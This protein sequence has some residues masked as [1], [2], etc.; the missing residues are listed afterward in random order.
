[1]TRSVTGR[2]DAARRRRRRARHRLPQRQRLS[3]GHRVRRLFGESLIRNSA[4]LGTNV[5]LGTVTGLGA[6]ILLT[7]LYP[8]RAIGLSAATLS[9]TGLITAISQL[10]LNYS[11][12]RFLPRTQ[13][14][15]DMINSALTATLLVALVGSVIFLALPSAASLYAM[16]G[17]AFAAVFLVSTGL[18]AGGSQL[19]NVFVAD[20]AADKL[21]HANVFNSVAR[22]AA[23]VIFVSAG[24]AGAY[25]AQGVVPPAVE[26]IV[27]VVML[28]RRGQRFR[29]VLS[30]SATRELR[31]FSVGTYIAG[32]IG[33]L[34][35]MVLPLVIV[36]RFGA[37]QSAYWY[38]AIAGASFLFSLPGA[39]SQALLAE[40]SHRPS[41]RRALIRKSAV[42]IT[43]VMVPVLLCAYLAAP[44]ALALL[45]HRYEAGALAT[46][47]WLIIAA[48]MSS[49]NYISGTIL[50]LAKKAFAIAAINTVDAIV[51]LGLAMTWAHSSEEVAQAWV[52]GEVC[53]VVLFIACAAFAL[54]QVHGRWEALGDD[55]EGPASSAVQGTASKESQQAGLD[56]LLS[57]ATHT[58]TG[59]IYGAGQARPSWARSRDSPPGADTGSGRLT[60]S[61]AVPGP[62]GERDQRE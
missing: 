5:V 51:V 28:A 6:L 22:L 19:Q 24:V 34:P 57:L 16:G 4:F 48:A 32:L 54:H 37:S 21:V 27:L 10:G 44:L 53:N 11:L 7:R 12:V 60:E 49:V 42:L 23:P 62:S 50:Y 31:R 38:T 52:I 29:P 3:V 55:E 8:V 39:V 35:M 59:P 25:L 58:M 41:A 1:M 40:A 46:L 14:R 43:A 33:G 2:E 26:F 56:M 61:G 17:V 30:A 15:A 47:R 45:G 9:A 20:R 36:S 13:Q 18:V